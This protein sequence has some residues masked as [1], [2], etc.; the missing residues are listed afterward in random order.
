MIIEMIVTMHIHD[1]PYELNLHTS[2]NETIGDVV[3]RFNKYRSPEK[4]IYQVFSE[5]NVPIPFT[6]IVEKNIHVWTKS[7]LSIF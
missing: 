6:T 3:R 2:E 1:M 4:Q 7:Y 5:S